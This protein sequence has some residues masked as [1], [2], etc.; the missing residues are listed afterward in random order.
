[1][2]NLGSGEASMACEM[3]WDSVLEVASDRRRRFWGREVVILMAGELR[4]EM[5]KT[6][7]IVERSLEVLGFVG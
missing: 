6:V 7:V 5:V 2:A 1:M 3:S 4:V